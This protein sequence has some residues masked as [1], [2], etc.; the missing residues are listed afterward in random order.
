MK[1]HRL[2]TRRLYSCALLLTASLAV[3]GQTGLGSIS[4]T[5]LDPSRA[6]I[7]N[8]AVKVVQ[9]STNTERILTT[10]SVG[11]FTV[12]SLVPSDYTMTITASGFK[13]KV[14]SNLQLNSFQNLALGEIV[15]ELGSG[16]ASVVNVSAEA[17]A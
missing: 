13:D 17:V 2:A 6:N 5:V 1:N 9:L 12:P 14:L 10:N 4:G 3:Y 11:I 16:P 7:A 8:A 15:L